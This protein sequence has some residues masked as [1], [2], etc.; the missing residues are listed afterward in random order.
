MGRLIS[1]LR[2]GLVVS[3]LV[4]CGS[5]RV[6]GQESEVCVQLL[7]QRSA[8]ESELADLMAR[9]LPEER[10]RELANLLNQIREVVK[11]TAS[12]A[13][14]LSEGRLADLAQ[15]TEPLSRRTST[16]ITAIAAGL[17]KWT[18]GARDAIAILDDIVPE[19]ERWADRIE[20]AETNTAEEQ[21]LSIKQWLDELRNRVPV[22]AV[23]GLGPLLA[24]YSEMIGS[25]ATSA[26]IWEANR[27]RIDAIYEEVEGQPLYMRVRSP[28]EVLADAR[29]GAIRALATID[30]KID[31]AGCDEQPRLTSLCETPHG[32]IDRGLAAAIAATSSQRAASE[33]R[34]QDYAS[35]SAGLVAMVNEMGNLELA[36]RMVTAE[37][38][39]WR[40]P[41]DAAHQRRIDQREALD[42]E[43][44]ALQ[45]RYATAVQGAAQTGLDLRLAKTIEL[46][47]IEAELSKTPWTA[48]DRLYL[49][50]CLDRPYIPRVGG[51]EATLRVD[52][53]LDWQKSGVIAAP[54]DTVQVLVSGEVQYSPREDLA[55]GGR[56]G[57]DG[58]PLELGDFAYYSVAA[59][60]PHAA[61]I[62]RVGQS[63][64]YVGS[65]ATFATSAA[66]EVE[67]RINDT[68][69]GNNA[70][71]FEATVVRMG[72]R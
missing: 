72:A 14:E 59:E 44:T 32:H 58:V 49:R 9:K 57:P 11:G 27:V 51:F 35:A 60:W 6:L 47:A 13:K 41:R 52:A 26:G 33:A 43:Y 34:Q 53:R 17:T 62:A 50:A 29:Q 12:E 7:N 18:D 64:F 10:L 45:T 54:G 63:L 5:N 55:F 61:V 19:L 38:A 21:I 46:K 3:V 16:S 23:P 2:V 42:A 20:A 28:R 56:A 65:G 1:V 36:A 25:I 67:L 69:T 15:R 4:L 31:E 40:G 8:L 48:Q 68:D 22:D 66:G 24:A 37:I 70:D 30:A 39:G 71:A